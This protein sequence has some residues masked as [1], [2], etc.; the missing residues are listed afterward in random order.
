MPDTEEQ[1]T[2]PLI[3]PPANLPPPK[4]LVIVDN[5][6]TSW[7]QWKKIWQRYEIAAGIYKQSDLVRVATLLSVIGEDA[8]QIFDTFTWREGEQD[9]KMKDVL[10]KFDEYCEPRTQVIYQRYRFNNRKQEAGESIVAYVTELRMIA[11]NCAHDGITPD[12][13]LR[14]RLVLGIR[15]D[16][17]REKLLRITDLTLQKALDI[18]KAAEQTSQQLK[19]MSSASVEMVGAVR[20]PRRIKDT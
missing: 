6:A 4:P 5:L 16:K 14:D 15:D 18:C 8:V 12:E 9:D 17:V 2:A 11:K 7:K 1:A 20:Q 13:I 19:M 10:A 3:M